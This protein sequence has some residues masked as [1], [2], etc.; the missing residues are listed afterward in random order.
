MSDWTLEM[1]L[2]AAGEAG[3]EVAS[4]EV[5]GETTID[6]F[7]PTH[8]RRRL[9]RWVSRP[10]K[11]DLLYPDVDYGPV[12]TVPGTPWRFARSIAQWHAGFCDVLD[13]MGR[14]AQA[15]MWNSPWAYQRNNP[16]VPPTPLEEAERNFKFAE[17]SYI[18]A[19]NELNRLRREAG[20]TASL[21]FMGEE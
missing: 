9:V 8:P 15:G 10:E 20:I 7:D 18:R 21:P 6:V 12:T 13:K 5:D 3:L 14:G 1:V 19:K 2:G 16:S 11:V 4:L 17:A